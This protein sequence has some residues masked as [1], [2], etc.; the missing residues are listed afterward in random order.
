M[1]SASNWAA[2]AR[3]ARREEQHHIQLYTQAK[4]SSSISGPLLR[5]LLGRILF[6]LCWPT[7]TDDER[8]TLLQCVD[9]L[10]R[11]LIDLKRGG[12]IDG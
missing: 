6:A 11:R 3:T 7:V 8:A 12:G 9:G 1:L 10:E 2:P 5:E 4:C